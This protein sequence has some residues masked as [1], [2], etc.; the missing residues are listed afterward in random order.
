MNILFLDLEDTI[1][2]PVLNGWANSSMINVPKIKDFIEKNMISDLRIFSFAIWDENQK[3]Q[4]E[5]WVKPALERVLGLKFNQIPTI[6]DHILPACCKQKRLVV[7]LTQFSDMVE[8]WGKDLSFMLCMKEWFK[9]NQE[10][11]E[12]FFLDDAVEDMTFELKDNKIKCHILNI[13]KI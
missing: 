7:E 4:F 11:R 1:I 5:F 8:F 3:K 12:I 9:D 13:D 6:D 2:E 10:E